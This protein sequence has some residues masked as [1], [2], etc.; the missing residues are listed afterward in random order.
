MERVA[1]IAFGDAIHHLCWR[2]ELELNV[3]PDLKRLWSRF[4]Q[5]GGDE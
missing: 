2:Y 3:L 5:I 4:G 1:K